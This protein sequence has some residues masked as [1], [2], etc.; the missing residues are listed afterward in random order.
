MLRARL[1]HLPEKAQCHRHAHHQLVIGLTGESNL[2][3]DGLETRLESGCVAVVPTQSLHDFQ[4]DP[5]N[6]VWV[7]DLDRDSPELT[8]QD[9]P[10]QPAFARLFE[11]PRVI[12]LNKP[13]RDLLWH[14]RDQMENI[15]QAN[16][17]LSYHL[18]AAIAQLTVANLDEQTVA[19]RYGRFRVERV[20][21]F[22]DLNM[23][24]PIKIA[25]MAREM[26]M[27]TSHFQRRFRRETGVSPRQFLIR[28]RLGR[29]ESLLRE[30]MLSIDEISQ[31]VG[32][33]SQSAFTNAFRQR[34]GQPPAR[35][36]DQVQSRDKEDGTA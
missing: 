8:D 23:H 17:V 2:S 28:R 25:D 12:T 15:P 26:C 19:P 36:R 18:G 1:V 7:I 10:G 13:V 30:G 21:R 14:Y 3:I 34:R 35:W 22:I 9:H 27:S 20:E 6:Q 33:C 31:R 4:G 24:R 32:F 16:E 5:S 11:K 29:A